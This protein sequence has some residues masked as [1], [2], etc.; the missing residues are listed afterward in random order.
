[1]R[2]LAGGLLVAAALACGGREEAP[3]GVRLRF[4]YERGDTLRYLYRATGHATIPD[5]V[6]PSRSVEKPYERR[7]WIEETA[8][9]ITPRGH[10]VL[11]LTYRPVPSDSSGHAPGPISLV[12]EITPQG[13]IV[14][15]RGVETARPLFGEIDFRSYFEQSQPVFPDRPLRPGDSWTQEVKVVSAQEEP[16]ET[17][18]TYVLEALTEEDGEPIA[19][20]AFDGDIYLPIRSSTRD[21]AGDSPDHAVALEQE[22]RVRGTIHFAHEEGRVRLVESRAD[23]TLTR[24]SLRAGEPARRA[25]RLRE[26][27]TI[28]LVVPDGE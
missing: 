25:V 22:I 13:R 9:E 3:A 11:D 8:T 7:M 14:D 17:S 12:V 28:R 1:M 18:S 15:V 26:E 21:S 24:L 19:V 27:S 10:Y 23:A 4:A 16:V 6:D 5:S 2:R 20:I